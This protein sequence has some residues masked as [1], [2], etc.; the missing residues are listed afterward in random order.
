MCVSERVCASEGKR[1]CEV[2]Q[3]RKWVI[4]KRDWYSK[5]DRE[6]RGKREIDRERVRGDWPLHSIIWKSIERLIPIV[7]L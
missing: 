7:E 4:T 3:V 5:I 1:V 6:K 2:V